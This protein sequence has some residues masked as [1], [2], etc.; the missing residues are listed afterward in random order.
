MNTRSKRASSVGLGLLFMLA[1]PLADAAISQGDRQHIAIS[2][3]G[4]LA[5]ALNLVEPS[6][7]VRVLV[8]AQ[9]RRLVVP[10][11]AN[12]VLIPTDPQVIR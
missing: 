5:T 4:I 3:S 11:A 6:A 9:A 1:P 8:P 10:A 2:Y 12:R 7:Y